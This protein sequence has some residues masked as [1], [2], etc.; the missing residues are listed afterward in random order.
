MVQTVL[1]NC[2]N[3]LNTDT[4][5]VD[6]NDPKT[7][8]NIYDIALTTINENSNTKQLVK[9]IEARINVEDGITYFFIVEL[10]SKK[11]NLKCKN[12]ICEFFVLKNEDT[13][14]YI[15]VSYECRLKPVL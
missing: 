2:I 6:L 15:L 13:A 10:K 9:I 12:L 8:K 3:V 11:C 5:I 4:E 1:S 14:E 7:Y